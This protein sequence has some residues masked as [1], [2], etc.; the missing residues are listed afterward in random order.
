MLYPTKIIQN[1]L[2]KNHSEEK[3]SGNEQMKNEVVI[4]K[5]LE[6]IQ[7]L[8]RSSRTPL[9]YLEG[10]ISL[11]KWVHF[12]QDRISHNPTLPMERVLQKYKKSSTDIIASKET[13]Y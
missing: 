8:R 13:N 3:E 4:S 5:N 2:N 1:A 11:D 9:L 7:V 12:R 10:Q 6:R